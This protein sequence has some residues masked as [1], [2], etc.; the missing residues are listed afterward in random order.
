MSMEELKNQLKRN[1]IGKVYLFTGPE[2]YLVRYYLKEIIDRILDENSRTFNYTFFEGKISMDELNN[3]ISLLPVFSERRIVVVKE[4]TL[5]KSGS[6]EFSW[7]EFFEALPDYICLVFIQEEI[8]KRT[9]FAKTIHK[10]GLIIDFG[11]QDETALAKWAIKVFNSYKKQIDGSTAAFFISLI[12]P[13]MTLILLEIEK[14]VR[15]MGEQVQ[16]SREHILS[17]VSKSIKSR[18]FDLM[19]AISQHQT[20]KAFG[21]IDDLIQLKEPVHYIMAMA[22][23]QLGM[24]M[25]AKKMEGKRLKSA[26]MA[27]VLGIHPFIASKITK[28]ASSFTTEALKQ[29]ILKC[30]KTDLIVKTGRM[31]A[32]TALELFVAEMEIVGDKL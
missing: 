16:V 9:S 6:K 25:K 24:L 5:L 2:Q 20:A 23:R 22:G 7:N 31:D 18:I 27:K 29:I 10:Y 32:R 30:A 11:R 28:Q 12:E 1:I 17:V 14:I 21:I 8:D 19:D 13:D 4:T 3:T 15:Y 26:E